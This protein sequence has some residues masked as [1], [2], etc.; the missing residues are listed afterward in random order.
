MFERILLPLDGSSLAEAIL[1]QIARI[2][3]RQDSEILLVRVAQPPVMAYGT[4]MAPPVVTDYR[5]EAK[6]YLAQLEGRLADQGARVRGIVEEGPPA[7]TILETGDRENATLIA[8]ATH[9]RT[10]IARWVFGSVTEKV[11]RASRVP[12][13]ILRSF[14]ATGSAAPGSF[15]RILVP[16]AHFSQRVMSYVREFALLFGSHVTLLH[17][18]ESGEDAT[19]RERVLEELKIVSRDLKEV[20]IASEVRERRGDPAHEILESSSEERAG[21]IAMTTHG[22]RGPARWALGSVTEKVLRAATTP[23]LVVRNL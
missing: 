6:A 15:E 8:M 5:G 4:E 22:A 9:G 23:M 12:V 18:I 1:P 19:A 2:L 20:G 11:L 14:P 10:G 16:I 7:G 13:L 17:V 3:K 21:L